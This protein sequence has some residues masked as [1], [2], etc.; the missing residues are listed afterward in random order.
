MGKILMAA[1]N[2]NPATSLFLKL[3]ACGAAMTSASV[4]IC[5]EAG[6][7][8]DTRLGGTPTTATGKW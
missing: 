8:Q 5:E 6:H 2:G 1:Q 7:S 3:T 4:W